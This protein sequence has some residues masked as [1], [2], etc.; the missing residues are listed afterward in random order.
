MLAEVKKLSL[1]QSSLLMFKACCGLLLLADLSPLRGSPYQRSVALREKAST[2][3]AKIQSF[4]PGKMIVVSNHMLRKVA[5]HYGEV[6]FCFF[7]S[8]RRDEYPDIL[9][10]DSMTFPG[11]SF[12]SR[13]FSTTHRRRSRA[14]YIDV[15]TQ[16]WLLV[17]SY[18]I[19]LYV[20]IICV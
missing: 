10:S 6:Q 14:S 5:T 17:S 9:G 4:I 18:L 15:A 12:N 2:I 11:H 3:E 8:T 16:G 20:V 13:L 1:L 19:G 7:S